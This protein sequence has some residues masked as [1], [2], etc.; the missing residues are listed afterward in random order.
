MSEYS[1]NSS[2]CSTHPTCAAARLPRPQGLP[3][4]HRLAVVGEVEPGLALAAKH[5]ALVA[6]MQATE[7]FK[8]F[9]PVG[10]GV[11]PPAA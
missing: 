6:Q 10:P 1:L 11:N 9:P 4:R 2:A 5:P 3:A 8:R 7:A